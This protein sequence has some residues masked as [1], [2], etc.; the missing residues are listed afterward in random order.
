MRVCI[1]ADPKQ[2]DRGRFKGDPIA[3]SDEAFSM[4][5][6]RQ[7]AALDYME[8]APLSVREAL[9]P[10]WKYSFA[11]WMVY[12]AGKEA[13]SRNVPVAELLSAQQMIDDIASLKAFC[14]SGGMD[15]A[16]KT[17]KW[18][19]KMLE[20][21][22][23]AGTSEEW[24]DDNHSPIVSAAREERSDGCDDFNNG[25]YHKAYWHFYQGVRHL[26]RLPEP[27]SSLQAKLGCDLLKNIAA[28]ALKLQMN[29]VAM[30]SADQ[31]IA[32]SPGDQKAWFRKACALQ[33]L[34]RD[35]EAT[36]AFMYAGYTEC[37]KDLGVRVEPPLEM[38]RNKQAHIQR[39][40][41]LECGIDSL[42]AIEL[43]AIIQDKLPNVEVPR[44]LVF[45][46]PT[47][48]AAT[49]F[50][51]KQA[52]NPNVDVLEIVYLAMCAVLDRD[53]LKVEFP[54]RTVNEEKCI[55][56][57]LTLLENYEDKQ[58]IEKCKELAR[59]ANMEYRTF[60]QSLRR[61]SLECQV[62][63]LEIRGF[64]ATFEGMRRFECAVIAC[65]SH[66]KQVKTL[67]KAARIAAYGGQDGMWPLAIGEA[68]EPL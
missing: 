65:A 27:L 55:G 36:E 16:K 52:N 20:K 50:L 22:P 43:I 44:S 30:N 23:A 18:T 21:L 4:S 46:Y 19:W 57:L 32:L 29:R 54:R 66:S 7:Y 61:H 28:A 12:D 2:P 14:E 3:L 39:L 13:E 24:G 53:P 45:N 6:E 62:Q 5:K 49:E 58:Y 9:S 1:G 8:E 37:E 41:F 10:I 40:V 34:D 31:A 15:K 11:Q 35:E 17:E 42:D 51:T 59:K 67:L 38:D 26:A 56:A 68:D 60:L 63:I 64:P 47:V 25:Q 33:N 48:G